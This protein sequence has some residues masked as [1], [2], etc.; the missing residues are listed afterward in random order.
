MDGIQVDSVHR[1]R[2]EP[3]TCPDCGENVPANVMHSHPPKTSPATGHPWKTLLWRVQDGIST[4]MVTMAEADHAVTE[5]EAR[6]CV[7]QVHESSV[8]HRD[9]NCR[10][11]HR[12]NTYWTPHAI[13]R[14]EARGRACQLC[15]A[16]PAVGESPE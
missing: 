14:R 13:P 15:A 4:P 7:Y 2:S 9:R 3:W 8:W 10:S 5:L 16:G 6:E 12:A 1:Y 11:L